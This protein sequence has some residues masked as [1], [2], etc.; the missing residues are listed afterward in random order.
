[1]SLN[2][3]EYVSNYNR[4][5]DSETKFNCLSDKLLGQIHSNSHAS[6]DNLSFR[7]GSSM[8]IVVLEENGNALMEEEIDMSYESDNQHQSD[9]DQS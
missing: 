5:K 1:M 3:D 9:D 7:Q 6:F 8:K 2:F 4:K